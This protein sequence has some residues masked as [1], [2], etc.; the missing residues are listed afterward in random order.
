MVLS[1]SSISDS[2]AKATIVEQQ[3]QDKYPL[4]VTYVDQH[5]VLSLDARAGEQKRLIALRP[6]L[7]SNSQVQLERDETFEGKLME[8]NGL[9]GIEED[10]K[11]VDNLLYNIKNLKKRTGWGEPEE[12]QQE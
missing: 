12:Q 11:T 5:A 1:S 3:L 7:D 8:L 6:T 10:P 4:D 9:S 2:T